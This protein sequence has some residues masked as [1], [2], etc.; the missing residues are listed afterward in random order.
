M[1]KQKKIIEFTLIYN[2]YKTR[3]YNYVLR[4]TNDKMASEDILQNVFLKFYENLDRLRDKDKALYWLFT[5]AR[6][7]IFNRYREKN[8]KAYKY[9]SMDMDAFEIANDRSPEII[10]E[11]NELKEMISAEL[12]KAP[13]EQREIFILKEYG[14]LSYKEISSVMG[15]DEELVKSRLYQMRQKLI[16]NIS[17]NINFKMSG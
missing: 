10:A 11:L 6:N 12:D 8:Y 4:M 7:E 13:N 15:I 14:G 3:I 9:N 17:S 16:K 5:T 2:R 1:S